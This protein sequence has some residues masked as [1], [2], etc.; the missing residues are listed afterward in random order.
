MTP[1]FRRLRAR[2]RYRRFDD[3]L[4]HELEAHRAMVEDTLR[5]SGTTPADVRR[6][7]A[8]QMGNVT[9]ARESARSI[10]IAPWLES[11]WQDARYGVRSLRHSPGFTVV[12]MLTLTLGIG[13]NL[14]LFSLANALLL[15]PWRA[16]DAHELV[17]VYHLLQRPTGEELV[18]ISAPELEFLRRANSVNVAGTRAVGG[19]LEY[20]GNTRAVSGRL[21][22][23]SYFDVLKPS[24]VAGR[25]LQASDSR[26]GQATVVVI[27]HEIWRAF[28]ASDPAI[29][30]AT[31]RFRDVP[32]T[33]VGVTGPG[34][35]E[36]PLT[37]T[38]GIWMPLGMMP[39]LFPQE[40]FAREFLSN[41]GHCCVDLVGR[42]RDG[43]SR[44]SA[45]A[46]LSVLDRQ[47]RTDDRDGVGMRVTGTETLY[48]PEA[49]KARPVVAL[50][51]AGVA[52]VLFLTCA[53]VG[54]L[55]LARASARRREVTIRQS[56]GAARARVVRQLLTEGLVLSIAATLLCLAASS[57]VA[58][59]VI[60]GMDAALA[61]AVDL[62]IDGRV[63]SFAAGLAIITCLVSSLAPA[64]RGTRH[65][66]AG[67]SSERPRLWMRS[68]FLGAQV[69]A[70]VVLL[71]AAML[72]GRGLAKAASQEMGFRLDTLMAMKVERPSQTP[73]A[74][75]IF[76]REVMAAIGAM[77]VAGATVV[78]LG[79]ETMRTD[80]RRAG[81][82]Y[83]ANRLV[84]FHPVS[85]S[86]FD[87]L[88]I[89]LRAGRPFRD[90]DSNEVV[91][92]E[93]LARMLWPN[94]DAVG[95]HLAG[96]GGT[97]GRRVVGV[98]ADAHLD[99]LGPVGPVLFQPTGSLSF[100]LF[101]DG[102]VVPDRLRAIVAA[103]DPRATVALQALGAN[104]G[105][106]LE[107]A[108]LGAR[109]AG[110]LSVLALVI[111]AA[112]T[113]GVFSF[114]VTERTREIGIRV[115]LGASRQGIRALLV[116]RTSRPILIGVS[117]GLLL[118]LL[119]GPVLRAYL[120]GLSAFDP[121][122]Y[123]FAVS[124]VVLTAWTS[125][126]VPMRRALRVDPAMT[127]RHE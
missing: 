98:V 69:A 16:P 46:E 3:D 45:E 18:G 68:A 52:L 104:V 40:A 5:A 25:P 65:L 116:R 51:F 20:G 119:T 107:A 92:N 67:R 60:V 85:S 27:S 54:N 83:E 111:I 2:L 74:E 105:T 29:V 70:S 19:N 56:L 64:L 108:S 9:L 31:I 57:L 10:W 49:A 32:V 91:L 73:D 8:R 112:G 26:S 37:G 88:G 44:A 76:R 38:P 22:S 113:A 13:V 89:P 30:G 72:L 53:N 80:V 103:A 75:R 127:L 123:L 114:V 100:L 34:I 47:F 117:L 36:S 125:V 78:P 110:A 14:S 21:V 84:Q 7:A 97:I 28:F 86:Y 99:N 24:I 43:S 63:L 62:S 87:V 58:R 81:E 126:V 35:Q 124:V 122:S 109:I 50:L 48:H 61:D 12:A 96:P 55:Q 59:V 106:S 90:D 120:Y 23:D 94:G 17:L 77:P 71:V 79:D 82:S 11:V 101:H 1:W 41:P 93:T 121:S 42:L 102:A 66:V 118:A 39:V 33:V 15:K 95:G 6:Q 4:R 115:A